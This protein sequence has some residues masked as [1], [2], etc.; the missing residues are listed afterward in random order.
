MTVFGWKEAGVRRGKCLTF[1]ETT[2]KQCW[3]VHGNYM[4]S[5]IVTGHAAMHS[6]R[7]ETRRLRRQ[8]THTVSG[9]RPFALVQLRE[10]TSNLE[11]I[12]FSR[13]ITMIVSFLQSDVLLES[14]SQ[15]SD[16]CMV[17]DVNDHS[18][19]ASVHTR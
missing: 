6:S 16:C 19:S 5:L 8:R 1:Q 12:K 18:G 3:A 15:Y 17:G 4:S 13:K 14:S 7:W 2:R 11:V 10:N 9:S